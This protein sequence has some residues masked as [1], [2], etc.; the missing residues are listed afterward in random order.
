MRVFP[1][2][3]NSLDY[4]DEKILKIWTYMYVMRNAQS[5]MNKTHTK[6]CAWC[7]SEPQEI[8]A[9]WTFNTMP[10]GIR[11]FYILA[12]WSDHSSTAWKKTCTTFDVPFGLLIQLCP[13][14]HFHF[15]LSLS[16]YA[17]F[18]PRYLSWMTQLYWINEAG[19]C[20]CSEM[21]CMYVVSVFACDNL[22]MITKLTTEIP[23]R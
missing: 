5:V 20:N 1:D 11:R 8:Y 18:F 22:K 15:V 3:I 21:M 6:T 13:S 7:V 17:I 4:I 14:L 10:C 12:I 23:Y 2:R 19:L 9:T 16:I